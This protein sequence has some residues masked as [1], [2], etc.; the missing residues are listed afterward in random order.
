M[1]QSPLRLICRSVEYLPFDQVGRLP[2][3]LR[4][5]YVLYEHT[6]PARH[7][8]KGNYNVVYVGMAR[9]GGIRGRLR[10]H[11]R[12]KRQLWTH[13]SVFEVWDNIRDDEIAELE[14]LFRHLYRHDSAA[15]VLNKQR[16][17]KPLRRAH[18]VALA[19][20]V[21]AKKVRTK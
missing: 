6:P 2:P 16:G 15:G 20:H 10:S 12:T 3:G 13:C 19:P 21:T 4:G 14:G 17:Y 11:R 8:R 18:P 9:T 5:I 1:P 7:S